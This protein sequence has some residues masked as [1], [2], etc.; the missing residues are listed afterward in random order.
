MKWRLLLLGLALTSTLELKAQETETNKWGTLT[1]DFETLTNFFVRDSIIGAANTPQYDRQKF[2]TSN[3]LTLNYN[4]MGFDIGV[5][6]DAYYNSNL[7][8]PLDSY[9]ALGLGRWHIRKRIHNLD[10]TGGYFYDQ[11]GNGTI[12]RAYNAR[13]L[14]IDNALVGARLIYH[15]HENWQIK[16]FV[17]QQKKVEKQENLFENYQPIIAG[18]AID[19]FVAVGEGEKQ[20]TFSPGA[21][22]VRRT[23]DD[24]SMNQVINDISSYQP[25]D[26]FIPKYTT[27]AFS[28]YNTLTWGG[29]NWFV[30]GAYKTEE[31]VNALNP[32]GILEN[33]PGYNVYTSLSYSRKGFSILGQYKRTDHFI[34]RTSPLQTLTQGMI[35][36]LPPMARQNTYRLTA[37]YNAATQEVGEQ[38]VQLDITWVPIP[39]KLTFNINFSNITTLDSI[40]TAPTSIEDPAQ[41]PRLLYREVNGNALWKINKK[42]KLIAG[43]QF[44]QY[45]QERYE[46]KPGVPLLTAITPY[47]ELRMRFKKRR[48][49]RIE[50]SYMQTEQDYGSWAFALAEFS[51]KNLTF[52]ASTMVNTLPTKYDDIQVFYEFGANYTHHSNRFEIAY[53]RQVEGIV[54]TGGVCRYQPAFNGVQLNVVSSF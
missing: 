41:E 47:A 16:A 30:E 50:L 22:A 51:A 19:G 7:I 1:G 37:R 6:F 43:L 35:A 46:Q 23:L 39:K 25:Q 15:L 18:A 20:V 42:M 33:R 54:C 13:Y 27:Y 44:Q 21:G 28:V 31:A 26:V 40:E 14:P 12:F 11:I 53:K 2:G 3:W 4:V 9:S 45:N 52:W 24:E 5:R 49:L 48:S 17:G 32:R 10:I 8:D 34:L 36:Y 29:F 38:A